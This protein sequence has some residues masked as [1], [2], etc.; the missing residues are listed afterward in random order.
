MVHDPDLAFADLVV[1]SAD[2]D[3]SAWAWR[4]HTDA[5]VIHYYVEGPCPACGAPAQQGHLA[6]KTA[7]VDAA[8]PE[9]PPRPKLPESVQVAVSCLCGSSHGR[10]NSNGCGRRWSFIVHPKGR[11]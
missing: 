7:P 6:L 11:T 5:G 10:Q 2:L 9:R 8:A 4:R 3:V 1:P